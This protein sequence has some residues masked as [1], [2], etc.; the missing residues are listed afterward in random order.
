M[1]L[2]RKKHGIRIKKCP[3]HWERA[4]F[5]VATKGYLIGME[6]G[7]VHLVSRLAESRSVTVSQG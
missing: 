5:I 7:D 4:F 6:M 3:L 1:S 2:R